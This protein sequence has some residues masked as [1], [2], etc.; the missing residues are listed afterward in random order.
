MSDVHNPPQ[1]PARTS[2]VA[3]SAV[4]LE[5]A[6]T[7]LDVRLRPQLAWYE[8]RAQAAKR[9]SVGLVSTQLLMT[10][11]IPV[12]NV[13]IGSPAASTILAALAA[14]ATGLLQMGKFHDNWLR[15]RT[16][17]GALDAIRL[18]YNLELPP[19]NGGDRHAR[20]IDEGESVISQEGVQWS[21]TLSARA[22]EKKS[23]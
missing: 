15:Y 7:Y 22:G 10:T 3:P 21:L 8:R 19:F 12:A 11:S 9:W 20:L 4:D 13:L 23:P 2:D 16:T 1:E 14:L 6:N 5:A 18:R 17:V